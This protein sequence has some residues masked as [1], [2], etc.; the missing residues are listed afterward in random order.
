MADHAGKIVPRPTAETRPYWQACREGQLTVQR[1]RDCGAHQFYPRMMCTHC[2]S[3]A[4]EWVP[5]SGRGTVRSYT[6][7]R[8]PVSAAYASETPYIVALIA[9]AEGPTL[10]SNVTGCTPEQ[11]V[12]GMPV[13]VWFEPWTDEITIPKFRPQP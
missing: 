5:V 8:R 4:V 10:M 6:V 9:L 11:I 2:D 3:D 13:E 12:V 1:C 7:V